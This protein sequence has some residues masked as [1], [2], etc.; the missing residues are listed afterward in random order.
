MA[1]VA[2]ADVRDLRLVV[3]LN[4]HRRYHPLSSY[5]AKGA[6]V[7]T[8]RFHHP[9]ASFRWFWLYQKV[10]EGQWKGVQVQHH[11]QSQIRLNEVQIVSVNVEEAE[12]Q[13]RTWR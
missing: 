8:G 4:H 9:N 7:W 1:K 10:F 6:L 13:C 2:E 5:S 12:G 3:V 11:P